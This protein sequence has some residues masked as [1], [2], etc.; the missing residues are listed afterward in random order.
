MKLNEVLADKNKSDTIYVLV[1]TAHGII[2]TTY[3]GTVDH[4]MGLEGIED[5]NVFDSAE[6]RRKEP[7]IL[8]LMQADW[9]LLID[10]EP[11]EREFADTLIHRNFQNK[12][13]LL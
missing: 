8:V 11:D 10:M 5:M 9:D 4:I 7:V 1:G 12:A 2:R 6:T 3:N 13:Y